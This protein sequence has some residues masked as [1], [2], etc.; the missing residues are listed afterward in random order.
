MRAKE[1]EEK[2]FSLKRELELKEEEIPAV[3]KAEL[4]KARTLW[5]KEK[6]EEVLAIQEQNEKDYHAFLQDHRNKINE[7]LANAKEDFA[8]QKDE[9]L[10]QKEADLK[11]SLE[12][13]RQE[14]AVQ[15]AKRLQNEISQYEE[16]TLIQVEL[17]LDEM[18]KDLVRYAG[19]MPA[20]RVKWQTAPHVQ[21]SLP[22]KDRLM[23][24]L[25]KAYMNVVSAV[26]AKAK[27]KVM[28]LDACKVALKL[29]TLWLLQ[30]SSCTKLELNVL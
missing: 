27:Q 5:N 4:A 11:A 15:E 2:I 22:F 18:H 26:L 13:K 23:L 14:W 10:E 20:W 8:K 3:V 29:S 17:L 30:S 24:C 16:R 6:Q 9:L 12:R 25:Q 1:L 7:S 21:G 28:Y 19:D